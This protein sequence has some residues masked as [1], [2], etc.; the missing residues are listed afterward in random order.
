M[1]IE[2]AFF[3]PQDLVTWEDDE[4]KKI[5]LSL[6]EKI[7]HCA[8]NSL[9]LVFHLIQLPFRRSATLLAD[10]PPLP[11]EG[12]AGSLPD[13]FGYSTSMY[14]DSGIGTRYAATS[15]AGTCDWDEW[16]TPEHIEG[17]DTNYRRFF[18]DILRNPA[19]Y[20]AILKSQNV[21]AHRLS[22]EWAVIEPS[23]GQYDQE[24]L[25]LY[26]NLLQELKRN[27]IEP[28]VTLHHFVCPKWFKDLGG[29]EKT[30]N[31]E[32]F[33][34]H[35]LKMME[36]FE[37][38]VTYWMPFNEINVDAFQKYCRGVYPPGRVRALAAAGRAMR[39]MLIAHCM[40]YKEAKKRWPEKRIGS[41]HQWLRFEPLSGNILERAV[42]YFLSKIT[43]FACYD[44]FRTGHFSLQVPFLAN[45][46]F[47]I[48]GEEFKEHQGFSDFIGVQFYGL[49]RFKAG[50]NGGQPYPG[51]K[52]INFG[53]F[54][55][56]ST[57]PPGGVVQSFGPGF[58]PESLEQC[59]LEAKKITDPFP[60]KKIVI[61]ETGCDARVWKFGE[62]TWEVDPLVQQEY[63]E[64]ILPIL[65]K[66]REDLG[67]VFFWTLADGQ[68]W[69][70]GDWPMLNLGKMHRDEEGRIIRYEP[71]PAAD[72]ISAIFR[73]HLPPAIAA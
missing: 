45:V 9:N 20:V 36:I 19:T 62:K 65:S 22:L 2:S 33:K 25:H 5:E 59:L 70:R 28:Y 41:T 58:Y 44:F 50:L 23:P 66:F 6:C 17:S 30:E 42:C 55:I 13:H 7:Q 72:F 8:R 39:A 51:Y 29:F 32:I 27:G 52:I 48:S 1:S 31:I 37:E 24:A 15:L 43:H 3:P 14:Q 61:T 26:K 21:T 67:G 40:I 60:G 71:S 56:G 68:E 64:K 47:S 18:F 63:F 49:P 53:P 54:T 10:D 73:E 35:A 69:E 12:S 4:L 11:R 38:E 16:L 57:C 46:Q 34:N